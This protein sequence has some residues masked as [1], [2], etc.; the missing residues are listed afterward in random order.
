MVAML[1]HFDGGELKSI[2]VAHMVCIDILIKIYEMIQ[3]YPTNQS[4]AQC[5]E[6]RQI[7][8]LTIRHSVNLTV[9]TSAQ[10]ARAEAEDA[11]SL[12]AAI[13]QRE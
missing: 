5:L 1:A 12:E 2:N 9:T 6:R 4:R 3:P 13:R 11:T 10:S 7:G 8:R